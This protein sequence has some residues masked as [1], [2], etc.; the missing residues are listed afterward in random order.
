M[1]YNSYVFFFNVN[2]Y[3]IPKGCEIQ[4]PLTMNTEKKQTSLFPSLNQRNVYKQ[5]SDCSLVVRISL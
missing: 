2:H 1:F 5:S 4:M 3:I